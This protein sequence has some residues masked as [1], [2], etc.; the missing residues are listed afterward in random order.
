MVND[1]LAVLLGRFQ[2]LHKGHIETIRTALA[3]CDHVLVVVGS[4][5]RARSVRD[6]WL[7][8]ERCEQLRIAFSE[9]DTDRLL[10]RTLPDWLYDSTHWLS[11]WRALIQDAARG[12]RIRI[13]QRD[14]H[15]ESG[16]FDGLDA[17][18]WIINDTLTVASGT[19]I[20]DAMF[21]RGHW[22]DDVPSVLHNDL[23]A[24]VASKDGENLIAEAEYFRAFTLAWSAAPYPP[25]MVT[26]DAALVHR[27]QVLLVQR[28]RRPGKGLW[29]L[30]GGFIDAGETREHAMLRELQEETQFAGEPERVRACISREVVFDA[31]YRSLRGRTIS[32]AYLVRW[33]DDEAQP[34]VR[35]GDDAQDAFWVDIDALQPAQMFE[36][37][38]D[39][40][41]RLLR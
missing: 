33:P 9:F 22:Q 1:T 4:A 14:P 29:A 31:P 5:E 35:G 39:M 12:R 18:G 41:Q 16:L 3:I 25:V 28:G 8:D 30:P 36:D 15:A 7:A 21:R 40:L 37:H 13:L 11:Q 26:V 38:W 32:T 19:V 20:R 10:V 27:K 17:T 24:F 6:P 34:L 2:P 23:A